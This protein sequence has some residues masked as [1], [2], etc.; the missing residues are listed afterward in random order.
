MKREN[1]EVDLEWSTAWRYMSR[2]KEG[3]M[4]GGSVGCI[5]SPCF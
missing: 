4:G 1:E 2:M 3:S 5:G